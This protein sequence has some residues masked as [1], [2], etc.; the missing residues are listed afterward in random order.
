MNGL[1][2]S[3]KLEKLNEPA[4]AAT[5]WIQYNIEYNIER[6]Q[7]LKLRTIGFG[8]ASAAGRAHGRRLMQFMNMFKKKHSGRGLVMLKLVLGMVAG[9]F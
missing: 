8:A 2:G 3:S 5:P 7:G 4:C 6:Y 9:F 1:G